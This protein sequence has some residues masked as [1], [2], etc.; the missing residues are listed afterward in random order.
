MRAS[1][2]IAPVDSLIF[3]Y[4]YRMTMALVVLPLLSSFIMQAFIALKDSASRSI[5]SRRSWERDIRQSI[6]YQRE[7]SFIGRENSR[8]GGK[9]VVGKVAE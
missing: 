6:V 1:A 8:D 4:V 7:S 9:T 3:F 2:Q 5:D